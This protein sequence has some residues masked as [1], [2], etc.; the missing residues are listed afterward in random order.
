MKLKTIATSC[1]LLS[2]AFLLA[3]VAGCDSD[4]TS[5]VP[6]VP[7]EKPASAR[8]LAQV[9]VA[10]PTDFI[11]EQEPLLF[12][13]YDLGVTAEDADIEYLTA[14]DGAAILP[15]QLIDHDADGVAD[16]LLISTTFTSGQARNIR[17]EI[18]KDAQK[19]VLPKQTQAEISHK[20]G[21][22]WQE[23]KYVGGTFENVKQLTPPPQ[24]T[25]HSEFIRYEG[26]GIESDKVG[27]R[28]YLDWR[29]GFDIFGKKT[30]DMVLQDVGQD[31]YQSY[32]EDSEWGMDLLK[33][34]KSLGAGGYGFWNGQAV[35]LVS[36]VDE[37]TATVVEDGSLHSAL[38]I[39]YKGWEINDQ[40]LD[41]SAHL[42]MNAGSRLVH[43]RVTLSE[44]LPNLAI[45][46]VKHPGTKL[47]QGSQETSGY[48]WT[49]V[50]SYGKQSLSG[51]ESN[52]GMALIFRR[53][54]RTE[55]TE[56]E[57]SYVSVM[58]TAGGEVEYYFLAAWDGELNGIKTEE[59]FVAYLEREVKRLTIAPRVRLK[60]TLSQVDKQFPVT[61]ESAL[62]WSQRLADS[63]LER[64]TLNYHAEGWD[65]NRRRVPNFEYD[66][67]GLLPMAY[68]E[69]A[70][71]LPDEKYQQVLH[72]VTASFITE[73]G[74]IR[75]YDI[76][77]YNIDA[78]KPGRAV[79]RLHQ[80]TGED[81]YKK[82]AALLN[83][84]L[85]KHPRTS[86][87][88]FWHKLSYPH[89]LWL[90]GVY[91]GMPFLAEYTT[92]FENGKHLEEV[93][94][95]FTI[96]R[97]KLRDP[98]TG[99]YY[100]AWDESK[101][102]VWADKETGLSEFFWGRGLGWLA[103]ALVDVLDYI[104]EEK[105]EL[106]Q[107]LLEMV[108]ELGRDLAKFQDPATG[109]WFQIMDQPERVG[110]YRES[111]ASAMFTYFYAKAIHKGY[112]PASY[113][114]TA[115]KAY[116]GLISEFVTVHPDGLISMTNQCLV[117][118][119]GFGRDGSYEYYM[120]ERVFQNDPKGTGPFI[121][122]GIEM[123]KMLKM[124]EQ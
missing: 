84:Q 55:Q 95:E 32:H 83:K 16:S 3:L 91:M 98:N 33:V 102:M 27:Y 73:D 100:H 47:L 116:E 23:K 69:L 80:Q 34:G 43:T 117:A 58:S 20:V 94:K 120:S 56:D 52:L 31:G 62:K 30:S 53:S 106:R 61:A 96:A 76:E 24:Y 122:A 11:R 75:G 10:N 110:N 111:S 86:E 46:M 93:V 71:I 124:A 25:D 99:L 89:Q 72:K 77:K 92:L 50:A 70:K 51:E 63:E 19:P 49:Y 54:H 41:L 112:L 5:A 85:E 44:D 21:G 78:I 40:K 12:S 115:I 67:V 90:D 6:E 74:D 39:D 57:S 118:G 48:A 36:T 108:T 66:I 42:S 15:S 4:K 109:T 105:T 82:A 88:A 29:N 45:G 17:I 18:D 81:K 107:P 65:L 26:P 113:K 97:D 35:D 22:E 14:K 123:H 68:D 79:L 1:T 13:F 2:S 28:I 38:K 37:W 103:M 7:V 9:E 87:G 60:S 64:K 101:E 104:P 59:E 8:L 114:D 121:I 119:L